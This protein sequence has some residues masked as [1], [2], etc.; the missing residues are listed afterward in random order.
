MDQTWLERLRRRC[1]QPA[2][3]VGMALLFLIALPGSLW[4]QI[5]NDLCIDAI[6]V[7]CAQ[8][9][10]GTLGTNV[11]ASGTTTP[12]CGTSPGTTAVWYSV[13]G[14]GSNIQIDTCSP[15]TVFDTKLNVYTG[16]CA[17]EPGMGCIGGNDDASGSPSECELGSSGLFKLSRFSWLSV[18]GVEYL[19]VVSGFGGA[20]GV[21]EL[22]LTC[23][24]P[25]EL[26]RFTIE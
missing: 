9:P 14:N 10:F 15:V 8:N 11:G 13:M 12:F 25:V 16:D 7:D 4:A 24:V 2:P 5:Q 18:A 19:V 20:S 26:Q 21:F 3:I 1:V 17:D 23:D 6:S 22:I